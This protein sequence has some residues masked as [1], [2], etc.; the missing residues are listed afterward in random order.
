MLKNFQF[1]DG[2]LPGQNFKGSV[3]K[4]SRLVTVGFEPHLNEDSLSHVRVINTS[5]TS[6]VS[7]QLASTSSQSI[8]YIANSMNQQAGTANTPSSHQSD[9][10]NSPLAAQ[11]HQ[12]GASMNN[13]PAAWVH[14]SGSILNDPLAVRVYQGEISDP[15]NPNERHQMDTNNDSS[16]GSSDFDP[17]CYSVDDEYTFDAQLAI[18]NYVHRK[19]FQKHAGQNQ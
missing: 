8:V 15:M 18:T 9:K 17:A 13:P 6:S 12:Y 16:A 11:V 3:V 7:S 10:N 19:T 4:R 5:D 1:Q 2:G 14:Q